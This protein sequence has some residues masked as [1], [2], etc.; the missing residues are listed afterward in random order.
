MVSLAQVIIHFTY[1]HVNA[2]FS[3]AAYFIIC[4]VLGFVVGPGLQ[5]AVTPFG[6]DG[7]HF[8]HIPINMF[9]MTGWI[10]VVM[11]ILNFVLFLPWNFT[12][13]RIAI[14][15]A[16]HNEGKETGGKHLI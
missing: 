8:L 12:E 4:Q 11:G 16:M 13:H 10:N 14:R 3:Y 9:T 5:A 15:E 2:M 1:I 7:V 6:E